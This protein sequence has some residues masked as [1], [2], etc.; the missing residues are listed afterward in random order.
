M[1]KIIVVTSHQ[2][3]DAFENILEDF[4][5]IKQSSKQKVMFEFNSE[6]WTHPHNPISADIMAFLSEI[7]GDA[8]Y[9]YVRIGSDAGDLEVKGNIEAFGVEITIGVNV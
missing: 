5:Y 9:A 2:M 1:H 3:S 4:E 8:N 6:D 7:V